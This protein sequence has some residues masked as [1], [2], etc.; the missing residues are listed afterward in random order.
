[1]AV[2]EA[3]AQRQLQS[4]HRLRLELRLTGLR[5]AGRT[6]TIGFIF[7]M[8]SRFIVYNPSSARFAP[9]TD[10][11]WI[12]LLL[13]WPSAALLAMHNV[14]TRNATIVGRDTLSRIPDNFALSFK[15]EDSGW[16]AQG[17]AQAIS[18]WT[19][20]DAQAFVHDACDFLKAEDYTR[21]NDAGVEVRA[22]PRVEDACTSSVLSNTPSALYEAPTGGQVNAIVGLPVSRNAKIVSTIADLHQIPVM[23]FGATESVLQDKSLYPRFSRT[24]AQTI[25]MLR[26]LVG[27]IKY[28][29][30]EAFNIV[31]VGSTRALGETSELLSEAGAANLTVASTHVFSNLDPDS[32]EK[33]I[34]SLSRAMYNSSAS[35]RTRVTVL[36]AENLGNVRSVLEY[37][38]KHNIIEAGF[39]WIN[40]DGNNMQNVVAT[41]DMSP[42]L[43]RSF[44]GWLNM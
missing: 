3:D 42:E 9:E 35:A 33:A 43:L 24:N 15:L 44:A 14:N 11:Y 19:S 36:I 10:A 28:F 29:G 4:L 27:V 30:W 8:T 38:A 7:P 17:A 37:G 39:V 25:P 16:S 40:V 32:V 2:S 12:K 26:A 13:R 21:V 23:S 5:I 34:L 31:N 18:A 1:M 20:C 41:N 6:A 22:T